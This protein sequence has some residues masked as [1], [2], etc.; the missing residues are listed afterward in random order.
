[1]R[2]A[3][4]KEQL[5][6]ILH[7]VFKRWRLI[8][9]L[10]AVVAISGLL[11]V[12]SRG[13]QYAAKGKVMITS[14]RADVTIQPTEVDSLALLKL[15][16][17]VVN[18]EV[19][20]I[21][22]RELIEQVVRGLALARAGGNVVNIA[23][24]ADDREAISAR[25]MRIGNRLKVTPIRN[26]NVIEIRFGSGD[27]S[28]AAQIV[29]RM[30]D[31]YLAYHAIVHS[32]QGLS[33]FYEE[34]SRVLMQNLRRAEESLSDYSL[35]EGI[36]SP[37]AEIQAAVT[38]RLRRSRAEL[39]ARNA[40]IVGTE[41]KLRVVRDQLAEQPEVVKRVQHLEVNPVVRQLQR[42]RGRPRGRPGRAAAQVHRERPPRARQPDEID[43]L[44]RQARARVGRASRCR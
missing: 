8:A 31:E 3:T 2:S 38:R 17:A 36:V 44:S 4:A 23:N 39:R 28:E 43:E 9:G 16:E 18:S 7:V 42:A 14:D 26:S 34:Q 40:S 20:L 12:L 33:D 11:A 35:R 25:A 24:A 29:N 10:F 5:F 19:H 15:N 1:M 30:I 6:E 41:E 21:R 32:Q 27:P 37:A 13:P 22:S